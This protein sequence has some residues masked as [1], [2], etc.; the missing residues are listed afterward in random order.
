MKMRV[1]PYEVINLL[2]WALPGGIR[3]GQ[4]FR[5]DGLTLGQ[6]FKSDVLTLGQNFKSDVLTLG[7]EILG[8]MK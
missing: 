6:N 7:H 3:V 5:G 2:S 4:R 1:K 8:E